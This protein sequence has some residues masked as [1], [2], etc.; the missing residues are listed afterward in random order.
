MRYGYDTYKDPQTYLNYAEAHLPLTGSRQDWTDAD[1]RSLTLFFYGLPSNDVT[2]KEQ[3]YVGVED[4]SDTYAE[5]RYG[6]Y[7]PDHEDINDLNEP[8]WH[9]WFVAL[10][11][12]ND[13]NYAAVAADVNFSN[14]KRL[15]IGFGNRRTRPPG[16]G[17]GEVRFDDIRLHLPTC[18]PELVKPIGDFAGGIGGQPDC[19]VDIADVGYMAQEWLRSDVNLAAIVE[20]QEPCDANLVAHWTLD[21]D[22]CDSSSYNHHGSLEGNY[23]WVVGY[24]DEH[25]AI[26]FTG[27]G[28]R[29]LVP[30]DDNTPALRPEHQVSVSAWVYFSD[31]QSDARAIVKG[32]DDHEAYEVEIKGTDDF[33]FRIGDTNG[34]N[35]PTVEGDVRPD[36]W[37]H[38]AGTYDRNDLKCYLNGEL[39]DSR[40]ANVPLLSQNT[41]GLAIGNRSDATDK[42][43]IGAVDEVCVYDYGLS[44]G[45]VAWLATDG[46]GFTKLNSQANIYDLEVPGKKAVNF[47]DIAKLIAEHWLEEKKWP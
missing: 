47:R 27:S 8:E 9:E 31:G 4:T 38:V 3:M 33:V 11:D 35:R 15:Y 32:E 6:D 39:E 46:T 18:R 12:F 20:L 41:Y 44:H 29:L 21:G 2:E 30:D 23:S 36:E 26:E 40:D 25:P 5:I 28:G 24:D 19:I 17:S 42:P 1:V 22:P 37:L 34:T 14:V 13:S 45:E 10:P 43:F 7:D 16:G